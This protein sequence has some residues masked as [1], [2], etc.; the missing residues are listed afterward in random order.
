[1][2][3]FSI[4]SEK[5]EYT[6]AN[7]GDSA[8]NIHMTYNINLDD[9][10]I[11]VSEQ[12]KKLIN[13]TDDAQ[14]AGYA[15]SI[16]AYTTDKIFAVSDKV[17]SADSSDPLGTWTEETAGSEP[18]SGNTVMDSAF[19]D[20]L[21]LVSESQDIKSWNGTTWASWW[22]GTLGRS[23]LAVGH[24]HL[25]WV[26]SDGNLYIV[27]EGDKVY[28]VTPTGSYALTGAGTLDL[29]TTEYEITCAVSNSTRS[30]LGT[31][32]TS[33]E[34]AVIVEWDMSPSASTANKY[35]KMGAKGVLCLAVW[36]DTVVAIL[37]NGIAKYFDGTSFVDFK[38]SMRF[39]V[40]EGYELIQDAIHP[41]GWA[42]I[43][44]LPH[45][46]VNGRVDVANVNL[47]QSKQAA[48][49]MPA[50]V[51][52][53]DPSIGLYHRFALG[54]GLTPQ[55]DYG[56]MQITAVGALYALQ[57]TSSKFL[58]SYEFASDDEGTSKSVLAYHDRTNSNPS[59]GFLMTSFIFSF[60]D[61]W[62]QVE[63]F[64]K[65]MASGERIK[66]YYRKEKDE[67]IGVSG[68]WV[69]TS[70]FNIAQI[71]LGIQQGNVMF[72]KMGPGSG[73]LLKVKEATESATVTEVIF[74]EANTFA[75]ASDLGVVDI[76]NFRYMGEV[77]STTLD[78]AS[79][80]IPEQG[81]SR[82]LQFLFEFHQAASNTMELDFAIINT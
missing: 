43:D 35:H 32:D 46:L 9:Q 76:L 45:F 15:A 2:A 77:T 53:L 31:R 26:G 59:R 29:S 79:L 25:I 82:K 69:N 49:Q 72:V 50:G 71:G 41:N 1:M 75:S 56:K 18:D 54:T 47:A 58:A 6:Q 40:R 42:I 80:N 33:G 48:Y 78:Y 23:A 70:K 28:K 12:V 64:H 57:N 66:L 36:S 68:T 3:N 60:R 27:D 34:E 10:R 51:W 37:S 55:E 19:F 5:G 73:Q 13:N 38:K 17:F 52:C 20:G 22:Q 61:I 62:K 14:F 63:L 11:S 24:R 16:G 30:F 4:P 44:D 8:G 67:S 7:K 81:R 74:E 65:K 21:F 39:P